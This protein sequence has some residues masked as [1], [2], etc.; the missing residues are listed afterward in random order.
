[1]SKRSLRKFLI[2]AA[3]LSGL[4]VASTTSAVAADKV[5][6]VGGL[7]SDFGPR[8]LFR[9]AGQAGRRARNRSTQ[10]VWRERIQVRSSV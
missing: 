1:M 8:L 10:Q 4:F 5:I 3:L 9:C 6:K 2:P 7:L